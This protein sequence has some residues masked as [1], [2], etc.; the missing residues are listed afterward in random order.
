MERIVS[1]I[2]GWI[3]HG[4]SQK[5]RGLLNL[6]L[7]FSGVQMQY[8]G[9]ATAYAATQGGVVLALLCAAGIYG[10]AFLG[11]WTGSEALRK[12]GIPEG[13]L[14]R[15][16]TIGLAAHAL[17]SAG[18]GVFLDGA[19][20]AMVLSLGGF[21]TGYAWAER[22]SLERALSDGREREAYLAE[23]QS[24][25]ALLKIL[26]PAFLVLLAG[27]LGG[28]E[29]AYLAASGL[30]AIGLAIFM[31]PLSDGECQ[32]RGVQIRLQDLARIA[33]SEAKETRNYHFA[34]GF[35]NAFR[36]ALF[37]IA[38]V[39]S[40]GGLAGYGLAEAALGGIA[41][42]TLYF[43]ARR[44][45]T[46]GFGR[47]ARLRAG[48]ALAGMGWAALLGST[49]AP[50]LFWVFAACMALG[51]PLLTSAKHSITLSLLSQKG[52]DPMRVAVRRE[53]VL[54]LARGLGM[55]LG[56]LVAL[57]FGSSSALAALCIGLLALAPL[58]YAIGVRAHNWRPHDGDEG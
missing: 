57:A 53:W 38:A 46:M 9:F 13:T 22:Q 50:E 41:A 40:L 30:L 11:Y 24:W 15:H 43:V 25:V 32:S 5:L 34:E 36:N 37:A 6:S 19:A 16:G 58:E 7:L 28:G 21:W 48:S 8:A 33:A 29:E 39:A 27:G 49:W 3:G 17:L 4:L 55:T 20:A 18:A 1:R 51:I 52:E 10:A 54:M 35:S 14:M 42:L 12:A 26:T 31:R 47:L 2:G 44:Q 45:G 56:A 23:L